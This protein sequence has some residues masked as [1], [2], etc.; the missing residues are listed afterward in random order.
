MVDSRSLHRRYQIPRRLEG[1]VTIVWWMEEH[2]EE[3]QAF[4]FVAVVRLAENEGS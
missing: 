3:E 1:L 4:E 2:V